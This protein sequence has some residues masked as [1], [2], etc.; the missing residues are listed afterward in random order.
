V[1]GPRRFAPRRATVA[2]PDAAHSRCEEEKVWS[3]AAL[4]KLSGAPATF[5]HIFASQWEACL[6]GGHHAFVIRSSRPD[7]QTLSQ[8]FCAPQPCSAP[9]L[10]EMLVHSTMNAGI[11]VAE[12]GCWGEGHSPEQCCASGPECW[13]DHPLGP[14]SG[15]AFT[16]LLSRV[17]EVCCEDALRSLPYEVLLGFFDSVA[18]SL[19][20]RLYTTTS[21][22]VHVATL[23]VLASHGSSVIELGVQFG[24]SSWG[25]LTGLV[26]SHAGRQ[27]RRMVSVDVEP[28]IVSSTVRS[29]ALAN[30]VS[31]TF[32]QASSLH[33]K[34]R[35]AELVFIDDLHA[36]AQVRA[37]LAIYAPLALQYIVLHDTV[38][39]RDRD[40]CNDH[41]Y[42]DRAI[43]ARQP[44][45]G[46][47]RAVEEFLEKHPE[48]KVR[49]HTDRSAGL[50][51][52]K[53]QS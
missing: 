49:S 9:L 24:D 41:R 6:M 53:R 23:R 32:L 16:G 25:L 11:E 44:T 35:P 30:N 10:K 17:V 47:Y 13:A 12:V 3:I 45:P 22:T 27:K 20:G 18:Y 37:E 48:W 34:L 43:C 40:E 36:Y 31:Y 33:V 46:I 26:E 15:F 39:W 8:M 51:V 38:S 19:P 52:L 4:Q 21:M 2:P 42:R 1:N 28:S 14:H 5:R 50:T 7:A 29:V